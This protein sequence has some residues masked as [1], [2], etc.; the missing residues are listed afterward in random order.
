MYTLRPQY[1]QY[2]C[3]SL[4]V[5]VGW[6]YKGRPELQ[7]HLDPHMGTN[8]EVRALAAAPAGSSGVV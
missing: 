3:R 8:T 6:P 7:Q 5:N 2:E 1:G 4:T